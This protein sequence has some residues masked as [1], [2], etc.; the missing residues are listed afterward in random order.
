MKNRK[1][2]ILHINDIHSR[3]EELAKI[4]T[5]I[6]KYKDTNSIL[7][8]A[9]DNA[10]F[11]RIET[12]G[13]QG[14][15]S[16]AIL[17]EMGFHARIFGN[18]EGFSG[19]DNGK[20]IAESSNCE[21][22]TC[23][24]Y[25][26][27]GNK[28]DFLK[29]AVILE[30]NN[31]K[32]LLIG[33]TASSPSYNEFYKLFNMITKD[34]IEEIHRVLSNYKNH[35]FNLIILIS[36]LGL[37]FDKIIAKE[38]PSINIIIGGHSHDTLK[39]P[40]LINNSIISQTGKYGENLGIL[41]IDLD[42]NLHI[43]KIKGSLISSKIFPPDPKIIEIINKFSK[44]A[45]ENMSKPLF[46]LKRALPHS[47]TEENPLSN[48]LADSLR[49]IFHTEIGIINSGIL[50]NGLEKGSISKLLLHKTS[51]SPL[52]PTYFELKGV[53]IRKS[54]EKSLSKEIQMQ[55]GSGAGFRGKYLGN[56][57]VSNNVR[58]YLNPQSENTCKI[59]S[60]TIDDEPMDEGKWYSVTSSDYLER[61]SGYLEM[62]NNRN[63]RYDPDFIRDVLRKYL[64]KE[65]LIKRA[66]L[67]RFIEKEK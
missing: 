19:I 32:I 7:L 8:D 63:G 56:L 22:L 52:N 11:M 66:F 55:D 40:V 16:S 49:D 30:I 3:F 21:V 39:E 42:D 6:E 65:K 36:H 41:D 45:E 5:A 14:E 51:P 31:V 61:G 13:T 12:E 28:L 20:N 57:A 67:K 24:I 48:F 59:N 37:K 33:V 64:P 18:N 47:L 43:K 38:F 2:R 44:I 9:G 15:I 26:I 54:L 35:E 60:I 58:I 1:L 17:N 50:N 4:S 53:D 27:E 29:D 34:P 46:Y 25:D 10:D 62:A 23:N